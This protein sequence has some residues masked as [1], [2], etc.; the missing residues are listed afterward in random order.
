MNLQIPSEVT[1]KLLS[2]KSNFDVPKSKPFFQ[3]KMYKDLFER[4][5]LEMNDVNLN[6]NQQNSNQRRVVLENNFRQGNKMFNFNQ[7]SNRQPSINLNI[8]NRDN[9]LYAGLIKGILAYMFENNVDNI[10]LAFQN[11]SEKVGLNEKVLSRLAQYHCYESFR[12]KNL[13][14]QV[15]LI[16]NVI[17]D[18]VNLS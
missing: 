11:E 17:N 15:A 10:D 9:N 14:D 8:E 12:S 7:P 13:D 16:N 3:L 5:N 6:V 4:N 1:Q 18:I 2:Y